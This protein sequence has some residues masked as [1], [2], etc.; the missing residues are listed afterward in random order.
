MVSLYRW[1]YSLLVY[2]FTPLE[3]LR[4]SYRAARA[5]EYRPRWAERFAMS[6]PETQTGVIWFHT[7]SVGETLA[8]LPVIKHVLKE[9]P[10]RPVLVT[11]M[12]PT[13]S[14][15]V[16]AALG[17]SV[18]HC[19]APYDLPHAMA[20]FY[21]HFKPAVLFNIETELWP[22]MIHQ[23][24]KR[25][26]P[27][28]LINARMSQKSADG[29][30]RFETLTRDMLGKLA[31]I[32]VQNDTDAARF[33]ELGAD[34]DR[35]TVTGNIKFDLKTPENLDQ[36]LAI[37][38]THLDDRPTW[39][40]ASTH[41]GEDEILLSAHQKLLQQ[42]PN[43]C[44]ILV[45]RHPE[46]FNSVYQLCRDANFNVNRR[47]QNEWPDG[48]VYLGDT[49]GELLI[50]C[51]LADIAFMGGSLV[52]T[53]GHNCLEASVFA[54]PV[55]SG[56]HDFNFAKINKELEHNGALSYVK[57]ADSINQQIQLWLDKPELAQ[58]AGDAG[59]QVVNANKGALSKLLTQ[60]AHFLD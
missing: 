44:L 53:G 7:V 4:L 37:F 38:K 19:Y 45:P 21:E 34:Q 41:Q 54:K 23:A 25:E 40:A 20:M 51:A 6:L 28:V 39:L 15:R 36:K 42:F 33:V 49:M 32:A 13:G 5:P 24:H 2:I 12:T 11:T 43:A 59:L 57:D 35:M 56:P 50:F 8:T 26:V 14:E 22:N 16:W 52:P 27:V 10:G 3:I 1:V 29:Y 9:Y 47:S 18:V 48:Q 58:K 60:L 30:R 46:R 17:D 55:M 31:H